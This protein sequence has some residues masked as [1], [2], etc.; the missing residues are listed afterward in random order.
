MTGAYIF[1]VAGGAMVVLLALRLWMVLRC[2]AV[3]PRESLR[4]L[5]VA[6]SGGHTTEILRLLENLSSAYC[7]RH[8]VI[9]DTDEMSAHKIKSFELNRPDRDSSVMTSEPRNTPLPH[10]PVFW[11]GSAGGDS[12]GLKTLCGP[13]E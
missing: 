11:V 4:L 8:Y 12:Q 3:V 2:C 6:G 1:A 13:Q 7:P 10:G 5:V 9:A